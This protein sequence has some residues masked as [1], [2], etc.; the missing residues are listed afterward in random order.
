MGGGG[1]GWAVMIFVNSMGFL[2]PKKKIAEHKLGEWFLLG[3][4]S[5]KLQGC[6]GHITTILSGDVLHFR[7]QVYQFFQ[8]DYF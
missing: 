5:M 7:H 4:I 6:R 1:L 2:A 8:D 3:Q